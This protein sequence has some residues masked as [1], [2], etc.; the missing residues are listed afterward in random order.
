MKNSDILT[1]ENIEGWKFQFPVWVVLGAI[2]NLSDE[3]KVELV[4]GILLQVSDTKVIA[5]SIY[6][7]RCKHCWRHLSFGGDVCRCEND[8]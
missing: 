1:Y 7:M 8:E 5:D 2:E 3:E 4:K 6:E